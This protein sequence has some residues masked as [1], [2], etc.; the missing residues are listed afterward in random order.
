MNALAIAV[1]GIGF[2]AL[3]VATDGM[4]AYASVVDEVESVYGFGRGYYKYPQQQID[5][6]M[7]DE[8]DDENLFIALSTRIH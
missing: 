1:D 7:Y 8:I 4:L 2:G 3:A 5:K 6:P